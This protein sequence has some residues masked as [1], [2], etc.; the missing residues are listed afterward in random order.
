VPPFEVSVFADPNGA[1]STAAALVAMAEQAL[2]RKTGSGLAGRKTVVFGGGPVG[3]CAAVLVAREQGKPML[4]RL[5]RSKPEREEAATRFFERYNVTIPWVSA[6][7]DDGKRT[8]LEGAEVVVAAAKAGIRI[9]TKEQIAEAGDLKVAVDVNAVP[10]T[11]IE[12]IGVRDSAAELPGDAVGIGALAVGDI[13]Y[14]V[15]AG[16]LRHM[17]EADEAVVLD[18]P[19]AFR[20]ARQFL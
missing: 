3:L 4:A 8:A 16:L 6:Q 18:F 2:L 5:T 11:G 20:L 10:P 15:Q 17:Q 12:G 19:D 14:K 13:K 7:T 1:Y 9:L